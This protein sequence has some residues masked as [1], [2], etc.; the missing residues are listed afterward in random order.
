M[1]I[2]RSRVYMLGRS[3]DMEQS[4]AQWHEWNGE[5]V[6]RHVCRLHGWAIPEDLSHVDVRAI[7]W[8]LNG[9][10]CGPVSI[11]V[12]MHLFRNGYAADDETGDIGQVAESCGHVTRM[13]IYRDLRVRCLTAYRDFML[14]SGHPPEEWSWWQVS[15]GVESHFE[16]PENI[17]QQVSR[18]ETAAHDQIVQNL[19]ASMAKCSACF[20]RALSGQQAQVTT[21]DLQGCR[22]RNPTSPE[23]LDVGDGGDDRGDHP[24]S[25]D[26]P[27]GPEP[28]PGKGGALRKRLKSVQDWTQLDTIR[29]ARPS[30]PMDVPLPSGA[31]WLKHDP[32]FDDYD[33]G[34]TQEDLTLYEDPISNFPFNPYGKLVTKSF[35]VTFR[36]YGYRLLTRFSHMIYLDT[37]GIIQRHVEGFLVAD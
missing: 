20:H 35:W 13:E 18:I 16:I 22:E 21:D 30:P 27:E 26:E 8:K 28:G 5:E 1:D 19:L 34:P 4:D 2:E 17:V 29:Y 32:F 36:D 10:D 25:R 6:Y 24:L 7:N 3:G 37:N 15:A 33:E 23:E 9:Y 31:L 14:L 12:V 11:Q